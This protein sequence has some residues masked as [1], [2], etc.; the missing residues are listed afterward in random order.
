MAAVLEIAE[1]Y[2]IA[3]IEDA[4]QAH[5]ATERGRRAGTVG[6]MGCFS[7]YPTKNLGCYGDGGAVVTSEPELHEK[8]TML[9]NYGQSVRYYH[10]IKGFNSRLDE[11]Q[12]AILR[13]KLRYLD[14]WNRRRRRI[15]QI[16]NDGL[17]GLPVVTPVEAEGGY[18]VYHLY[19][20]QTAGRDALQHFL[21]EQGIQTLVHYPVPVHR[22]EAY[23][24]LRYARG[25]LPVT[26]R[27][28]DAI[29]SLPVYPQLRDDEVHAVIEAVRRFFH[30]GTN[31]R[32]RPSLSQR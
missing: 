32:C 29:L 25:S 17:Q 7:F 13:V 14:E 31:F 19:V 2:A 9:R 22:Q 8:L 10:K 6:L 27:V 30:N 11:L 3:V 18:H 15:A 16:Y 20:I 12:A 4:A 21:H 5:G 1:K 26:E 28:A 23:A 24:E